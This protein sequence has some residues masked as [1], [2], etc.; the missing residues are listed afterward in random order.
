MSTDSNLSFAF[1]QS[2]AP[3]P[4][5]ERAALLENPGFG[6]IFTDHMVTIRYKEGQGWHDAKVHPRRALEMDPASAVLHYAQEIFEGLKA[7][8]T[9]DGGASLFRAD[10]NAR[11][12]R[13]SAER[14]AMA[15]LPEDLFLESCRQL[16]KADRDWIPD[17]EGSALYLRP[18][19][20]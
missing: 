18:F 13:A 12:F 2:A 9:Q 4:V 20:I 1:E 10:A 11:R 6:R 14:L 19:M 3:M 7:Y 17:G 8:R 15:P 5:Q 16:V